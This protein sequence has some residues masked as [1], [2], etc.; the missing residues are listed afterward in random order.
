MKF[1]L[2]TALQTGTCRSL[3][4]LQHTGAQQAVHSSIYQLAAIARRNHGETK[5][6]SGRHPGMNPLASTSILKK[7][8]NPVCPL[9]AIGTPDLPSNRSSIYLSI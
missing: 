4:S 3:E 7:K 2:H 5:W 6:C 1:R 8:S 9:A